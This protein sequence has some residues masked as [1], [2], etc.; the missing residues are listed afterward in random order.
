LKLDHLTFEDLSDVCAE[1]KHRAGIHQI[2][3][4]EA[5]KTLRQ[6]RVRVVV[7]NGFKPENVSAAI[8]GKS[9]G[10]LID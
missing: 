2:I 6:G 5:I 1:D 9:V 7:V 3:D 4:P 10:T 8:E